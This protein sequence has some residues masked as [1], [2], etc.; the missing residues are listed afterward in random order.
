MSH[1]D[2]LDWF[3][4]RAGLIRVY[5]V[6]DQLQLFSADPTPMAKL[7]E[8]DS[9]PVEFAIVRRSVYLRFRTAL[10]SS[11]RLVEVD[12]FPTEPLIVAAM[13]ASE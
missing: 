6:E 4:A 12:Q 8:V 5:E 10:H 2:L 13:V 9:D 1:E 11:E 3:M 7:V